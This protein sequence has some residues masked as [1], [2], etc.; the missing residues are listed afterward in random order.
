MRNQAGMYEAIIIALFERHYQPGADVVSFSRTEVD[1]LAAQLGFP[2]P[3][4]V[5]D[6][7][8]SYRYRRAMPAAIAACAP[9]GHRWIIRGKGRGAYAFEIVREQ[10][11][12]EPRSNLVRTKI[13][14][15]TPG[16]I[17]LYAMN[18]EQALLARVRYNRLID[19]F[20]G[21][22]CHALQSHLRTHVTGIG[23]IEVDEIYIGVAKNG[24]HFVVPVQAKGAKDRLSI[25]QV[26]QDLA[27][28]RNRFGD[29]VC[30]AVAAQVVGDGAICL[31]A[32]RDGDT[33][34][35]LLD[36]R[37]Y[38]LVPAE[39]IDPAEIAGYRELLDA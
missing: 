18:D 36:E 10:V 24:A 6:V 1:D 15:C 30:R 13:P 4:N 20:L 38:L 12:I 9:A 5:G 22:T 35:E 21:L 26:E 8:Y 2:A 11:E 37:H 28:C 25:V 3:S 14:D 34:A 19:V 23:Q 16:L 31:M 39:Q 33:G 17:E 32:F 27:F 29:L 7:F